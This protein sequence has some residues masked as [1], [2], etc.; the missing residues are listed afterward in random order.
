[1]FRHCQSFYQAFL[2][3]STERNSN[4]MNLELKIFVKMNSLPSS[5]ALNC[6]IFYWLS[7]LSYLQ[8]SH[9]V[10]FPWKLKI[11]FQVKRNPQKT[12][13]DIDRKSLQKVELLW[14]LSS[15]QSAIKTK[16]EPSTPS[17]P[18]AMQKL[19]RKNIYTNIQNWAPICCFF[20]AGW[21]KGGAIQQKK[22]SQ[23]FTGED[24]TTENLFVFLYFCFSLCHILLYII[25][26]AVA[27]T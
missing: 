9:L 3:L 8:V 24:Y 2:Y 7:N 4:T 16:I 11:D 14:P 12:P 17:L 20:I 21:K 10:C 13:E 22:N 26:F 27:S 23:R 6:V 1:M 18:I 5:P 15:L 25:F 19:I